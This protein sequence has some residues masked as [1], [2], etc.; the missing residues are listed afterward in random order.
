[1][2]RVRPNVLCTDYDDDG[3]ITTGEVDTVVGPA[4]TD[5]MEVLRAL[6]QKGSGPFFFVP[7]IVDK[8]PAVSERSEA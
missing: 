8:P 1:M 2:W 5:I 7:E 6:V 3:K 4:D